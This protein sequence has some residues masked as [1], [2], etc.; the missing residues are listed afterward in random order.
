M[1]C[2]DFRRMMCHAPSDFSLEFRTGKMVEFVFARRSSVAF[3]FL[4]L[5]AIV[6]GS[7]CS[8]VPVPESRGSILSPWLTQLGNVTKVPGGNNSGSDQCYGTAV[9]SSGSV[10]CAGQTSG[11]LGE[12]NGGRSDAF[13]MK[14]NSSGE[15]QWVTHLGAV[16]KSPGG[17]NSGDDYCSSIALDASGNVYCGG[18]TNGAMREGNAGGYDAFVLKL[19]PSGQVE[20]L[21]QLGT[22]TKAAGG[23]NSGDDWLQAVAVD[24]NGNVYAGGYTTGAVG[25]ANANNNGT[26]DVFMIKLDSGGGLQW[27]R[28]LGGTTH[29][30]GGLNTGDDYCYGVAVDAHGNPYCAGSTT[31]SLGETLATQSHSD[32]F[33]LKLNPSGQLQWLTQMGAATRTT[34]G[35]NTG[36]DT[37]T[38]VAVDSAGGVFVGGYSNGSWAEANGSSGDPDFIAGKFNS[39][40]QLQWATQLGGVTRAPGGENSGVDS[41][42]GIALDG[43]GG[44]YLAGD[45]N[46]SMGEANAWTGIGSR[47]TDPVIV[48]LDSGG[49][50][51]WVT[52]LGAVTRKPGGDNSGH[53]T[54]N[55]TP[56]VD[57]SGN[58][59]CGGATWCGAFGEP[60]GGGNADAFILKLTP[61]G[62]LY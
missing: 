18:A 1:A 8:R 34:G 29:A 24:A 20:W 27:A 5:T 42:W 15:L 36:D 50:L 41:C 28:Q 3:F 52:Q 53:D 4:V 11:A 7:G 12:A 46:G 32:A 16:T 60:C 40:G 6:S 23:N 38:G 47:T 45:T 49:Q 55:T 21:T 57:R 25:E 58:V 31:G 33:V 22:T 19:N 17:S 10:Y 54:C 30:P 39:S 26:N 43:N 48:K 2:F 9:D 62:K 59:Y 56:A 61:E 37:F 14:L 35:D 51:H 13:V 44:V